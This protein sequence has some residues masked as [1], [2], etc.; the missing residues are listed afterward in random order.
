MNAVFFP[1]ASGSNIAQKSTES[2]A[3]FT[4]KLDLLFIV[5]MFTLILIFDKYHMKYYLSWLLSL[6]CHLKCYAGASAS[7]ASP[8]S[9]P[10]PKPSN[11]CEAG[12]E[13]QSIFSTNQLVTPTWAKTGQGEADLLEWKPHGYC[14]FPFIV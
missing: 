8:Q 1:F 12:V 5:D 10:F 13:N 9:W 2:Q 3:V 6:G 14:H 11:L 7:P 4:E